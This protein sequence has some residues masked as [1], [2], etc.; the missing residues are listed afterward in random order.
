MKHLFKFSLLLLASLLPTTA[1]A[2]DFEVDGIYYNSYGT[3]ATV[4]SCPY[5]NKYTGDVA[6]PASVTY[7]GTTYSV[8]TIGEWAFYN[9]SDLTSID[10]PNPVTSI[11]SYAFYGCS[12]LTSITIPNSVTNIGNYAFFYCI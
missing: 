8:T 4:T 5:P 12:G 2:Y 9:C 7:G 1:T 11:G 3:K 6:I 10:I